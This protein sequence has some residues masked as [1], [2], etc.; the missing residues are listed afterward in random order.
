MLP[1]NREVVDDFIA[2]W[3]GYEPQCGLLDG[4]IDYLHEAYGLEVSP[5]AFD[6]ERLPHYLHLRFEIADDRGRVVG[7][8][9]DLVD[10]QTRLA[11]RVR[12]RFGEVSKGRFEKSR[13]SSWSFG[14]LP[15]MVNLD[16][17]TTGFPGLHDTGED[18][19]GMRLWASQECALAQHRLGVAA[20]YRFTRREPLTRLLEVMF[21]GRALAPAT[22]PARAAAKSSPSAAGNFGS[23][24]AAFGGSVKPARPAPEPVPEKK[25]LVKAPAAGRF[26]TPGEALLFSRIGQEPKRHRDDLLRRIIIDLAGAPYTEADWQKASIATDEDLFAHAATV[27]EAVGKILRVIETLSSLLGSREAGYEESIEDARRHFD[28][29]LTPGWLLVADFGLT[30]LHFQGLEMRLTR[31][32]GAAPLKDLQKLER[33]EE[34][35]A[36]IWREAGECACGQCLPAIQLKRI[37]EADSDLRL[38]CFAPEIRARMK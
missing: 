7:T 37:L 22:P 3:D 28:M 33:Y 13:I 27:C 1:S 18:R 35:A 23:L 12:D 2:A 6:L 4:L 32:L 5:G 38:K 36:A 20:L 31:M 10:L 25:A 8:G 17:H 29:L 21:S 30:L 11:D 16:R 19:P 26:L 14:D 24:A 9:T 15:K 34:S